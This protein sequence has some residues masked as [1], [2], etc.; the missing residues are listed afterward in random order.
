MKRAVIYSLPLN[1]SV[2]PGEGYDHGE[3]GELIEMGN[4]QLLKLLM[5]APVRQLSGIQYTEGLSYL[6]GL[7]PRHP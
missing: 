1:S 5:C 3:M 2:A 6:G 7:I 4:L